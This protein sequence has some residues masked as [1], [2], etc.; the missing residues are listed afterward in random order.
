MSKQSIEEAAWFLLTVYKMWEG[1]DDFKMELFS[2]E[3]SEFKDLEN[4]YPAHTAK[5]EKVCLEENTKGVAE[6]PFYKDVS[7]SVKHRLNQSFPQ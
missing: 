5:N 2:K 4:S 1:R 3:E 7:M 6:W